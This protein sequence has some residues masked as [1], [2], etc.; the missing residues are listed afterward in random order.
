VSYKPTATKA[1]VQGLADFLKANMPSLKSAYYNWPDPNEELVY[2]AVSVFSKNP[3]FTPLFPYI[4]YKSDIDETTNLATVRRVIGMYD[5]SLQVDLWSSYK[6]QREQLL[7]EFIQ[8]MSLDYEVAGLSLQLQDY[9][10][11]WARYDFDVPTFIDEEQASQRNEWRITAGVFAN[12]RVV[13]EYPVNLIEEIE[14]NIE[15]TDSVLQSSDEDSSGP[16]L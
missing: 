7:E 6:A 3:K 14:N 5:F 16:I 13:R 11:Q 12:C 1:V 15:V 4:V 2:P 8:A 10:D 9:Y